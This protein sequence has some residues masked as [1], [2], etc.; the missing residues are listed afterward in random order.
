M[1]PGLEGSAIRNR[2]EGMGSAGR[3]YL[4]DGEERGVQGG[5]RE[6]HKEGR[7]VFFNQGM[8]LQYECI[9]IGRHLRQRCH[10]IPWDGKGTGASLFILE[11]PGSY[12]L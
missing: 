10:L 12:I 7:W 6:G 3:V 2:V 4:P 11:T 8:A 9:G 5:G 1:P